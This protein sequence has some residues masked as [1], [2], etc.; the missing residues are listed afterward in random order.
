[1]NWK[2]KKIINFDSESSWKDENAP[3]GFH[4]SKGNLYAMSYS[5]HWIG[6]CGQNGRL[7]WSAGNHPVENSD[8]HI[9]LDLHYPHYITDTPDGMLLVSSSGNKKIYKI[10]PEN[11][12]AVVLIDGNEI[13]LTD[14]G[15]CVFDSEGNIWVNEVQGC[16]LWKFTPE[17]IPVQTLGNG[18]PGFQ[19]EPSSFND[20]QFNWIYDVRN[21]P[22]GNIY[23]L[24]SKNYAVRMIDIQRNSVITIAGTGVGGYSGDGEDAINATFGS[25]PDEHFDGPWSLS[26]D[27]DGNIYVGDTQNHVV[28]MIERSTNIITTIAGKPDITQGIRNIPSNKEPLSLDLPKICSMDYNNDCLYIP[29]WDGD[30]IILSKS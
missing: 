11:M 13:G 10:N 25:N 3:F 4:D 2:V 22:D 17:G 24:D 7:K 21:G 16:K 19:T 30:L 1:M 9:T 28:R 29:E 14:L 26:L 8:C 15:N 23:V 18:Q 20:V 27:E 6:Y 5:K 12:T